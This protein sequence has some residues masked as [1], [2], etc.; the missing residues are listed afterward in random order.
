MKPVTTDPKLI[1]IALQR[2]NVG[3]IP[4]SSVSKFISMFWKVSK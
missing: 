1:E 2:I 3:V 4:Q